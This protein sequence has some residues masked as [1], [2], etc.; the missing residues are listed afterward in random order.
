MK[1]V[2]AAADSGFY[3]LLDEQE[4]EYF[5]RVDEVLEAGAWGDD[6]EQKRLFIANTFKEIG[7]KELKLASSQGCSRLLEK[8]ISMSTGPQL[9]QLFR[10]FTGHFYN[11]VKHRFA[12]HCV[13]SLFAFAA[14]VAEREMEGGYDAREEMMGEEPYASMETMVGF[15][16]A[17][18]SWE[19]ETATGLMRVGTETTFD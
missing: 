13:E 17:V 19:R 1:S 9:K 10:V 11:L 14:V 7:N 8:L 2:V 3:G 6:D 18:S 4:Q 5:R 12:S 15:A 16:V